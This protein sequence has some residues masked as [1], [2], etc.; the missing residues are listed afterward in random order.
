MFQIDKTVQAPAKLNLYLERAEAELG[1]DPESWRGLCQLYS[2]LDRGEDYID[3]LTRWTQADKGAAAPW[4]LLAKE[5]DCVGKLEQSRNAWRRVFELRGYVKIHCSGCG[6]EIRI[7]YNS[8]KGFDVYEDYPCE[9][10]GT[11]IIMPASL[12]LT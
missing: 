10:C 11:T 7:P 1:R 5:F 2:L 3:C 4:V 9:E 12:A 8:V 6:K